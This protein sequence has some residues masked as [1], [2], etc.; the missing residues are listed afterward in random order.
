[1]SSR[2]GRRIV[3]GRISGLSGVKGWVKL[4]SYTD[5]RANLLH[6]RE[7]ALGHEETWRPARLV[8]GRPQGKTVIGRFEGVEDRDEAAELVGLDISIRR[9]QLPEVESGDVY[10]TDLI[11]L[12]VVNLQGENLGVVD[13]LL[14]TGAND[15]LVVKGER[16]R[17]IP[18]VR[19]TV[20]IEIDQGGE[21]ILVDWDKDY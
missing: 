11:G 16:E 7:V 14:E 9:Q 6:F 5:P 3:V 1:V 8:E 15:V 13:H 2:A 18:F 10:W 19:D 17:L 4:F 12:K 21:R 20:V